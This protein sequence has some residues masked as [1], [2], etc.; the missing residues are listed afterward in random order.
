MAFS[1]IAAER[2]RAHPLRTFVVLPARR[3]V[4]LWLASR[5]AS[6]RLPVDPRAAMAQ[7]LVLGF[8]NASLLVA[9]AFGI[10]AMR[11]DRRAL[12]VL[13]LVPV[14]RSLIAA[15]YPGL[16][17]RYLD[18]AYPPVFVLAAVGFRGLLARL[19]GRARR[20]ETSEFRESESF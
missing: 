9:A 20:S 18:P 5:S 13:L 6:F 1:A 17:P 10:I 11:R 15:A 14:Y 7:R 19:G 16:E 4:A 8:L 3:L 12:T 2:A